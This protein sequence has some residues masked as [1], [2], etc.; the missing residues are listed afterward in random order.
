[1]DENALEKITKDVIKFVSQS[2]PE[3]VS[4]ERKKNLLKAKILAKQLE[5]QE[6][7]LHEN[8]PKSVTKVVQG[9]KILLWQRLLEQNG[10]EVHERGSPT[11]G[12]ARPSFMLSFE[13]ETGIHYGS[14]TQRL[15]NAVQIGLGKQEAT[16]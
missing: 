10:S 6:K 4:I 8:L 14:R 2:P 11:G 15:S 13:V 3:L 16:N 5:G 1:M 9:K 7:I 12:G